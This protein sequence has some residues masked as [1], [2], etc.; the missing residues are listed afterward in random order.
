MVEYRC[1][2]KYSKYVW[3]Y[4]SF[5]RQFWPIWYK[6]RSDHNWRL[7][8]HDKVFL[9]I[10]S[11]KEQSEILLKLLRKYFSKKSEFLSE[12][13]VKSNRQLILLASTTTDNKNESILR[14]AKS[15]FQ[16]INVIS[17]INSKNV[18]FPFSVKINLFNFSNITHDE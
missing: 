3:L 7:W 6:S 1:Y 12:K 9:L 17:Q 15:W 5:K 14:Q 4:N 11:N 18:N 16:E 8:L 10:F 13:N 2:V